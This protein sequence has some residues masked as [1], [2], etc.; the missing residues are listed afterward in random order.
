MDISRMI[1]FAGFFSPFFG[2]H[3]CLRCPRGRFCPPDKASSLLTGLPL[4]SAGFYCPGGSRGERDKR[5]PSG[6]RCP[7]GSADPLPCEPGTQNP[8]TGQAECPRNCSA[9][10]FCTGDGFTDTVRMCH[11][12][13]VSSLKEIDEIHV[14]VR[15]S[16]WTISNETNSRNIIKY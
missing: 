7:K 14:Y 12:S 3:K 4:C 10:F 1:F 11:F 6:R 8:S 2:A 13:L 16:L 15:D 5:C 9:G